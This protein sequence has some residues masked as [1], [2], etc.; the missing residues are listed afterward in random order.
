[1]RTA[2]DVPRLLVFLVL[3]V[4]L[5]PLTG[6]GQQAASR[7]LTFQQIEDLVSLGVPDLTVHDEIGARG[8]AFVPDPALL[9]SLRAK[10]AGPMTLADM[11]ALI[12]KATVRQIPG[13]RHSTL[14]LQVQVQDAV[15]IAADRTIDD[16]KAQMKDRHMDWASMDRNDPQTAAEAANIQI[17]VN[18]IAT[19][20]RHDFEQR[21]GAAFGDWMLAPAGE[22]VYRLS[23]RP[24][25]FYRMRQ[26]AV[27]GVVETLRRRIEALGLKEVEIRRDDSERSCCNV[28]CV[29]P[30]VTDPVRVKE[31]LFT[32]GVFRLFNVKEG[33]FPSREEFLR[34]HDGVLPLA[35][36][37]AQQISGSGQG[38]Y[39]LEREALVT[40]RDLRDARSATAGNGTWLVACWFNDKGASNLVR[41]A[42]ASYGGRLAIVFDG[43][44]RSVQ[45][46]EPGIFD[47]FEIRG[48]E[49]ERAA[50]D[51][52]IMLRSG[53]LPAGTLAVRE[54]VGNQ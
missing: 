7:P 49:Q 11:T 45:K 26:S 1:M 33:P 24:E 21:V 23:L 46:L 35:T 34:T 25:A 30:P 41:F 5:L 43:A 39:L 6:A 48:F 27:D 18:G 19:D 52:A 42:H 16:L 37:L 29:F 22:G 17:R 9:A 15:R 13:G 51:F 36:R 53:E 10:G 50:A 3:L 8:L 54:T 38:W 32:V 28:A 12:P 40:T 20:G 44:V 47:R 31:M 14:V 2:A 4:I